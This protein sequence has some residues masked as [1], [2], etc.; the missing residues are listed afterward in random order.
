M[1]DPNGTAGLPTSC[2]RCGT[3]G[4][5]TRRLS[6]GSDSPYLLAGLG[7]LLH[8]AHFDVVVCANC[9]LTRFFAEPSARKQL[10]HKDWRR[11]GRHPHNG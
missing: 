11:L 3:D 7:Q 1:N 5:Y 10:P 8:N 9:G 2:T 4:L 6:S